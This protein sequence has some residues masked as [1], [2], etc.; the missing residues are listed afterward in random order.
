MVMSYLS[1]CVDWM[2]AWRGFDCGN[3]L[4]WA[5]DF[6][7]TVITDLMC[8]SVDRD[9]P[10]NLLVITRTAEHC[11]HYCNQLKCTMAM[12]NF[13]IKTLHSQHVRSFI[14]HNQEGIHQSIS[15]KHIVIKFLILCYNIA[16]SLGIL[17]SVQ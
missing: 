3:F 5:R 13:I 14:V 4:V 7:D 16:V 15:I 8:P 12:C 11:N 17:N 6:E 1:C 9:R 10:F 2:D